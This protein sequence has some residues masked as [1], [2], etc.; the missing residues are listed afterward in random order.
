ADWIDSN[1]GIYNLNDDFYKTS[2]GIFEPSKH[3]LS[4]VE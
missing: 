4:L 2:G 3:Y 1:N